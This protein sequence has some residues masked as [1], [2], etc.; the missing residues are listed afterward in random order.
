MFIFWILII[1]LKLDYLKIVCFKKMIYFFFGGFLMCDLMF[2]VCYFLMNYKNY[3]FFLK[4]FVVS[5]EYFLI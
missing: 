1:L 4:L 3:F 5:C 2:S